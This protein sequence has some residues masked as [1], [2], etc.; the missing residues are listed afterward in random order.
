M[1]QM[2]RERISQ[3]LSPF[4]SEHALSREQLEM[5]SQYLDIL[6]TWNARIN[7][8]AVRDPE[9]IVTRHFGESL[10]AAR[11]F[12]PAASSGVSLID[13]G[14]GAGFPGLPAKIWAPRLRLTLIESQHKKA[15]FL[16][17]VVRKLGLS[18]VAVSAMRAEESRIRADVVTLR[19]VERFEA[20]LGSIRSMTKPGGR[21]ALLIGESQI[22]VARRSLGEIVWEAPVPIPLSRSRAV[23]LGR[24]P[25]SESCHVES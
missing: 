12:L 15:V 17:E 7:L 8:T 21:L 14:T 25:P 4:L 22:E 23:L 11:H 9:Q 6:T 13:I 16:K 18:D 5:I 19:A 2:T 24:V 3:L 1:Q 20:L 10:F